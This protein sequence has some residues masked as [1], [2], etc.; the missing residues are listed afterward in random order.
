[1]PGMRRIVTRA[2]QA[3]SAAL[4]ATV[5]RNIDGYALRVWS[6]SDATWIA[7][8]DATDSELDSFAAAFRAASAAH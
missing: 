6:A 2:P 7:V 1:M 4:A 5:R 8:S 3:V